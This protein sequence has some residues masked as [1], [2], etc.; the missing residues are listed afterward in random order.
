MVALEMRISR[1]VPAHVQG[2]LRPAL[3]TGAAWVGLVF[4]AAVSAH[5]QTLPTGAQVVSGHAAVA[6]DGLNLN[7]RQSTPAAIISWESFSIGQRNSVHV[8]NGSGATLSRVHGSVASQ[9]DGSLTATGSLYLVN[10]AGVAVGSTGRIE[11]GGSFIGSTLDLSDDEF[12]KAARGDSYTLK[13]DSGASVVNAGRIGSLGGDVALVARNVENMGD[14]D[15]PNGTAAL[16]AGSEV[17][18]QDRVLDGGR[19]TVKVGGSGTSVRNSGNIK[20]AEVELRA[21][22]G[23]VYALAGNRSGMIAATGVAKRDGRVFLTAGDAGTVEVTQPIAARRTA[24]DGTQRAGGGEIRVSGGRVRVAAMLDAGGS[25]PRVVPPPRP[26]QFDGDGGTVIVI[27]EA[28]TLADTARINVS[29]AKGGVALIGGDFQGGANAAN[30]YVAEKVATAK[31]LTVPEGATIAADGAGDGGRIVLWSDE[32]TAFAGHVSA[33]SGTGR[34]GDGEVSGKAWLGFAG[35]ADLTGPAGAGTLLLDP[36][37]LEIKNVGVDVDISGVGTSA[38]PYGS[39][40]GDT[41]IL[42]V[43]TLIAALGTADVTVKTGGSSAGDGKITV[44]D[45]ITWASG[46][47]LTLDAYGTIAINAPITATAGGLTLKA[48][49]GTFIAPTIT[50]GVGGDIDVGTFYLQTGA[51]VQ[52]TA[53]LPGFKAG[54]FRLAGGQAVSGSASAPTVTFLRATGGTGADVANAWTVADIYGLQGAATVPNRHYKLMADIDASGTANWYGGAGFSPIGNNASKFTGSFD[55]GGHAV[56]GLIIDRTGQH[57]GGL[58]GY[59]SG[60]TIKDIGL[61]GGAVRGGNYVGGL[62]GYQVGGT[63]TN[64][65]TTGDVTGKQYVGGLIGTLV[66]GSVINV[67]ATGDVTGSSSV[68]GGLVGQQGSGSIDNAHATGT[69]IATGGY[70]GGLVGLSNNG[71]ITNA[72]AIGD[73]TGA[74]ARAGGLVGSAEGSLSISNV[75]ATGNVKA[76]DQVGGLIGIVVDGPSIVNAYA[77]GS[78]TVT[79]SSGNVGGLIGRVTAN[80]GTA[81]SISGAYATGLI[82][83]G[84]TNSGGLV[85]SQGGT[86]VITIQK[87]FWDKDA[88]GQSKGTG[89]GTFDVTGLTTGQLQDTAY[90]IRLASAKGWNFETVWAPPGNGHAPELYALSKVIRVHSNAVL[91]AQYGGGAETWETAH[92]AYTVY[93]AGQHI[94]GDAFDAAAATALDWSS[95]DLAA[96]EPARV[97]VGT[98]YIASVHDVDGDVDGWR[99]VYTSGLKV[100]QKQIDVSAVTASGLTTTREYNGATTVAGSG[101]G[102]IIGV[103]GETLN[104]TLSGAAFDDPNAG[105]RTVTGTWSLSSVTGGSASTANYILTGM[106]FSTAGTINQ[107]SISVTGLAASGLTTTREY[108]GTTTIIGAGTGTKAGITGETLN[109]TLTGLSYSDANA[110]SRT[111]T[112]TWAIGSV[113]GGKAL[114]SNYI[115]TGGFSTSGTISKKTINLAGFTGSVALGKVYDGTTVAASNPSANFIAGVNGETLILNLASPVYNSANAGS[116]IIT[117]TWS[118]GSVTGGNAL[119]S[120]YT[121]S[122]TALS[123]SGTITPKEIDVSVVVASGL[124]TVR[125]Y[126]GATTVGGTGVGIKAGISGETLNLKLTGVAFDDANASAIA[127]DRAITGTWTIDT[128]TGGKAATSNYILTGTSFSTIGTINKKTIDLTGF[129]GGVALGKVYDGTTVAASNPSG[130]I[131]AGVNGETLNLNLASLVYSDANAGSRTITGT[132]SLDGVVGGNALASN[133]ILTG[134][135]ATSGTIAKKTIDLSGFA[136]AQ[137]AGRFGKTY[138]ATTDFNHSAFTLATGVNSQTLALTLDATYDAAGAGWRRLTGS[139]R[140]ADGTGLLSNYLLTQL[141]VDIAATIAKA[142]LTITARDQQITEG[143]AEPVLAYNVD[144]TEWK[145]TDGP[146]LLSGAL[147]R[148]S[149]PTA[150]DYAITRGTLTAGD[151]YEISFT[152]ATLRIVAANSSGGGSGTGGTGAGSGSSG[153]G[154]GNGN[155]AASGSG[156]DVNAGGNNHNDA[157]G[158]TASSG[159]SG[160][161]GNSNGAGSSTGDK[162]N[163]IPSIERDRGR[164]GTTIETLSLSADAVGSLSPVIQAQIM[165]DAE[166][167]NTA[168]RQTAQQMSG[169]T[170]AITQNLVSCASVSG[171]GIG[172]GGLAEGRGG[173]AEQNTLRIARFIFAAEGLE[174]AAA[175]APGNDGPV[176]QYWTS[177][178]VPAAV[179]CGPG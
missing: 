53:I 31:T 127:G 80:P 112:G 157:G 7:V 148:A 169:S 73:V 29:G 132:W 37:N 93:G 162:G 95:I 173:S 30:N 82:M 9:I 19:F 21:N 67:Y 83:S 156:G 117:G 126:D 28:V 75:Y 58:F 164:F 45:A 3:L 52:N 27:G 55:G 20:A 124:T 81:V 14:I 77:T 57:Y 10:P 154:N 64:A 97:G 91:S 46:K 144:A 32:R 48:K 118:L 133:Y 71:S 113:T 12:A 8:D 114:A 116:R 101:T 106:A 99:I 22:G 120:N 146:S 78:V 131:I 165:E 87:S 35:T 86:G 178:V 135:F 6:G 119:A 155:G 94:S 109:L 152:G 110:G 2:R 128:V 115:L 11:T 163:A 61:V 63:I 96:I 122:G 60:A 66:N 149:G 107:K 79:N 25:A 170:L 151:N 68:V 176:L 13:G 49:A 104:L 158:G 123:T 90:F 125:D 84:S 111:I 171:E 102:S 23:N 130:N 50:T 147:A 137:A 74:G 33:T 160:T 51:W 41:S 16:A 166:Q 59:T 98:G 5:A 161:D 179:T 1:P 36:Y 105:N 136:S 177:A 18:V 129:T 174:V 15:A 65:Y 39:V 47:T 103:F 145:V 76:S 69:V 139:W 26:S 43:A 134:G 89:S 175:S 88:T 38:S 54:D 34:G 172:G 24:T 121:L 159:G 143:E 85:G 17:L 100:T 150:G 72:W 56:T 141:D 138:D 40:A 62:V 153:N 140:G 142:R 167:G 108:D 168:A 4:A 92:S 42:S 70:G 44:T